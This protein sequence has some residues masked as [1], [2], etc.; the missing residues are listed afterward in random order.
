MKYVPITCCL[1]QLESFSHLIKCLAF[2]EY[3]RLVPGDMR[4]D[5]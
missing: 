3:A 4:L 1:T 2:L 5:V